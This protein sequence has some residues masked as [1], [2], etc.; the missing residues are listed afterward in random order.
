MSPYPP[1]LTTDSIGCSACLTGLFLSILD[2][3][4]G[5]DVTTFGA[6]LLI[7]GKGLAMLWEEAAEKEQKEPPK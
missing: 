5:P 6:F 3:P 2:K 4:Y 7:I 1:T